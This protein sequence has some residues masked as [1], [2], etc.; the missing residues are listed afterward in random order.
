MDSTRLATHVM[1]Q[2]PEAGSSALLSIVVPVLNESEVLPAFYSRT[3]AA[4]DALPAEGEIVF[5]D[6]GSTDQ[7][8]A[9][10]SEFAERDPRVRYVFLSRNF[11]HQVAISA[12][13]DHAR[14]DCVV[15]LDAD[16]QDPPELIAEMFAKWREG[17]DVVYAVRRT[18]A[19]ERA[20]KRATASA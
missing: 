6:D 8:R 10:I 17:N 4:L 5:V 7:S 12:G 1:L 15:T 20:L 3:A 14:G 18:R 19:G 11:G 9:I 2:E 13:I 16:L